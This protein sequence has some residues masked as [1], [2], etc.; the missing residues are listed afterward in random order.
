MVHLKEEN[1]ISMINYFRPVIKSVKILLEKLLS[2]KAYINSIDHQ[3]GFKADFVILKDESYRQADLNGGW[4]QIF[5]ATYLYRIAGRSLRSKLI[6]IQE[7]Q[8]N[9]QKEDVSNLAALENLDWQYIPNGWK[10]CSKYT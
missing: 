1:I 8:S 4:K 5:M 7:L 3:S 6:W 9:L 10:I 2:K